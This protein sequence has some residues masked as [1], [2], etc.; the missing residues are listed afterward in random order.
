M[1]NRRTGR[2]TA[3]LAIALGL[4]A[5]GGGCSILP[6]STQAPGDGQTVA[7]NAAAARTPADGNSGTITRVALATPVLQ[8]RT[9]LQWSIRSAETGKSMAG[10]AV[11]GPDGTIVLGPY[12]AFQVAGLT[13]DQ[14]RRRI[15][16]QL[17]PH[18]RGPQVQI[19]L[20]ELAR[21]DWR[22]APQVA[23]VAQAQ[24]AQVTP[25]VH[26]GQIVRAQSQTSVWRAA[27]RD[28]VTPVGVTMPPMDVPV[29]LSVAPTRSTTG[30]FGTVPGLRPAPA[31]AGSQAAPAPGV[32]MAL[33]STGP[34]LGGEPA[35]APRKAPQPPP[36]T[37]A[38]NG[39]MVAP[40]CAPHGMGHTPNEAHRISLPTYIIGPPDILQ[41]DSLEGLLTQP[42]RG[43]HLVRP[44]GTVGVGTY[45]SV[46]VAGMTI[47]QARVEIAKAVYTR[48]DPTRKS[49][50]DVI[51]GLSVDVL[52]YN[53]K[54]YYVITD[55]IGFGETVQKFPVTGN[56]TVLDAIANIQG[57]P[58]EASRHKVWVA[59]RTPDHH[60]DNVLPVDWIAITQKGQMA[61]NYQ[62]LPGDRVYVKAQTI[63]RLDTGLARFL[64]PIQRILG[65]MLLGSEV[66]NSIKFHAP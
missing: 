39:M 1:L 33:N 9:Q 54:V 41:I 38:N 5:A 10:G 40:G 61:T 26:P 2:L 8:P 62:L 46:Y 57:L 65:G 27:Q 7:Q 36:I 45:G 16:Q 11:V 37:I 6:H 56:D 35:P 14:A 23:P 63:Q 13:V 28:E 31:S 52:A 59:R 4:C 53:S 17:A 42:V 50:K 19:A 58:P 30:Q 3:G 20:A 64:S 48:L 12:G 15:E 34:A 49:L 51:E 47:E 55:R 24:L 32:Q 18:V 22:P 25:P 43:P 66:Y 21:A 60:A 44:D 29:P